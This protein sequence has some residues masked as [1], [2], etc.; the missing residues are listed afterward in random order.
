MAR[1]PS[2]FPLEPS[3]RNAALGWARRRRPTLN[4]VIL[5]P[6]SN[7]KRAINSRFPDHLVVG[8]RQ[9]RSPLKP[10]FHCLV[11]ARKSSRRLVN[12]TQP[13]SMRERLLGSL[14]PASVSGNRAGV[15][16]LSTA[17]TRKNVLDCNRTA[18]PP[19]PVCVT[20]SKQEGLPCQKKLA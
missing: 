13:W 5:R 1:R 3:P 8:T 15:P 16:K 20:A 17:R 12:V 14:A 2:P 7:A 4:R 11:G 9:L 19:R 6:T 10:D 18:Q